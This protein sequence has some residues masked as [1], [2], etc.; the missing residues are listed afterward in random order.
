[1]SEL[2]E[3]TKIVENAN[4]DALAEILAD[5]EQKQKDIQR[6]DPYQFY[7]PSSGNLDKEKLDFLNKYLKPEDVPQRIDGQEDVHRCNADI[8]GNSGGN[9]SGKT[10]SG[11]I[12]DLALATN[13]LPT[14]MKD[15]YPE[16]KL[17]KDAFRRLRV[18]GVSA[19]QLADTVLPTYEEWCPKK[20]LKRGKFS[21]SFSAEH[22]TLHLFDPKKKNKEIA[23]IQFKT[24]EQDVRTFQGVSLHKVTYDEEPKKS[25]YKENMKRFATSDRVRVQFNWTP[26]EGLT[27]ATDLFLNT[28]DE[29]GRS[30]EKFQIC[31]ITNPMINMKTLH[32]IIKDDLD[33]YEVLKMRLLGEVISLSGLIYGRL[34]NDGLH[35]IAPF[36]EYLER[37][38]AREQYVCYIGVD[39]HETFATAAT[40]LLVDR[41]GNKYIDR[42]YLE[43]CDTH[44]TKIN[45]R[46]MIMKYNYRVARTVLDCSSDSDIVAFGGRN[47][48]REL[49][50]GKNALPA[51]IGSIKHIGSIHA[52]VDQIKQELK[53]NPVTKQPKIFVVDRPENRLMI[54]AFKTLERDRQMN[55]DK[56]GMR[57]KI[58]ES[59][60]HHHASLRYIF[61]Y[62]IN[63]FSDN[64]RLP[65]QHFEDEGAFW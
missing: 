60:H 13:E 48:F 34:Y 4:E 57:D 49:T 3:L 14:S 59:K 22:K 19:G 44:E 43:Q 42:C 2:S 32:E 27:W 53:V 20:F 56:R 45:I 46:K 64:E 51:S 16:S 61:Q 38:I 8:I 40:F 39:P 21:E 17:S 1:M 29:S 52:G 37:G 28:D 10:I 63:W 58:L 55:E 7:V 35:K 50:T 54:N 5:I 18:V 9:R 31:P 15:W 24:N 62:P 65:E 23:T 6:E 26:T 47:I 25:I 11:A 41:E 12:D 30:I 33:D 36:Y